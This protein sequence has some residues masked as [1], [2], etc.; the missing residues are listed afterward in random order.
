MSTLEY[1]VDSNHMLVAHSPNLGIMFSTGNKSTTAAANPTMPLVDQEFSGFKDIEV[2]GEDNNFPNEIIDLYSK[3]TLIP[4]LLGDKAAELVGGGLVAMKVIRTAKGEEHL[5]VEDSE[6]TDWL[7]D[8]QLN[9]ALYEMAN[10]LLWFFNGWVELIPSV[11]RSKIV[12]IVHQE[13]AFCRWQKQNQLGKCENVYLCSDWTNATEK[14]VIKRKVIDPYSWNSIDE[15]RQSKD[16]NLFYPYNLPTVGKTFYQLA[17][18]DAVRTSGW[19]DIIQSVP[20]FKKYLL[21][22]SMSIKYHFEIDNAYWP[23]YFGETKW[24]EASPEDQ[25]KLKK[26][27]LDGMTKALT[28]I[29]NAGNSVITDKIWEEHTLKGYRS[30]V[31][32]TV[33]NDATKDG[34]YIKDVLEGN[35][36]LLYA[37]GADP[38]TIGFNGGGEQAQRS[39]GSDKREAW[40]IGNL[41]L[42]PTRNFLLEPIRWAA[43]YNGWDKRH[44]GFKIMTKDSILTTTDTGFGAKEVNQ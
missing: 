41:R 18:H 27:W 31:T 37:F 8:F 25:L 13:A 29:E 1:L 20:A 33:L 34:T 21:K 15:V 16:T 28:N 23:A 14:N 43:K 11:D 9:R 39:G 2:W 42:Q 24:E 32:I 22:N 26:L 40:L 4:R 30:L 6:I 7:E 10:D 44:P 35:S 5:P 19:L 17:F 38:T 36:Q 12:G 3:N